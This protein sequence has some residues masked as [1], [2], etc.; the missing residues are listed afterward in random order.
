MQTACNSVVIILG[1]ARRK[2]VHVLE[3]ICFAMENELVRC[4]LLKTLRTE[5]SRVVCVPLTA[6][7]ML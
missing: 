4:T 5:V 2:H 7:T 1:H 6:M 3:T